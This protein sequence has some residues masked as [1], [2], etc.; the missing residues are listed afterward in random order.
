MDLR[1]YR[2]WKQITLR[3][4]SAQIAGELHRTGISRRAPNAGH[5]SKYE[6]G[7]HFPP[8]F[9]VQAIRALT[10]GKVQYDDWVQLRERTRGGL[11]D[12]PLAHGD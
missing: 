1:E 7:T 12:Q 3:G 5:I 2:R 11:C 9:I 6:R 4:M 8:P 10:G